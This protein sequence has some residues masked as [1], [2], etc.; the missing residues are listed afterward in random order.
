LGGVLAVLALAATVLWAGQ[1]P[2]GSQICSI[3]F[4]AFV[5]ASCLCLL[6]CAW[7]G[8]LTLLFAGAYDLVCSRGQPAGAAGQETEG[9]R[10]DKSFYRLMT[11]GLA[12]LGLCC[13]AGINKNGLYLVFLACTFVVL[14]FFIRGRRVPGLVLLALT[15]FL[16]A[17][18]GKFEIKEADI[19]REI[20]A[21]LLPKPLAPYRARLLPGKTKGTVLTNV[22]PVD[23]PMEFSIDLSAYDGFVR[24]YGGYENR[25][26]IAGFDLG[27]LEVVTPGFTTKPVVADAKFRVDRLILNLEVGPHHPSAVTLKLKPKEHADGLPGLYVGP[28]S[29]G[30]DF[31]PDAIWMQSVNSKSRLT[32]HAVERPLSP[33]PR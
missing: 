23:K 27:N 1:R 30:L 5:A 8:T 6:G 31:Y 19:R 29:C 3:Y 4:V 16:A 20:D 33:H 18:P 25:I 28:E 13:A 9:D 2:I 14:L 15:F 24:K 11:A 22:R 26:I 21:K 7:A 32:F 10:A 12:M 17:F